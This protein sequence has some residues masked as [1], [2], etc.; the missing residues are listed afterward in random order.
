MNEV[1]IEKQRRIGKQ[2]LLVDII[3]YENDT[4]ART[5]FSFVT[6]DH[7]TA[8]TSME[9]EELDQFIYACSRLDPFSMAANGAREIAYGEDWEKPKRYKGEKDIYGFIL[10]TCKSYGEIVLRSLK[11]EKLR[12]LCEACAKSNYES[13]C[14]KMGEAFGVS[15]SVGTAEEMEYILLSY[16]SYAVRVIHQVQDMG[17]DWDVIDGMLR[18]EVSKDRFSALE[19]YVKSKGV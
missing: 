15:E 11:L 9:K 17:Y 5:G 3:H 8:W 12:D 19:G 6:R 4:A 13:Y 18:M 16:I 7:M 2:L 10:Y 1:E 14:E